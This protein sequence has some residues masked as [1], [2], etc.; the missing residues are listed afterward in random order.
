MHDFPCSLSFR[1]PRRGAHRARPGR[2]AGAVLLV[3]ASLALPVRAAD[4]TGGE[5]PGAFVQLGHSEDAAALTA[6]LVWSWPRH[7]SLAGGRLRLRGEVALSRWRVADP[8]PGQARWLSVVAFVPALRWQPRQGESP[9]FFEVGVGASYLSETYRRD[10]QSFSTRWNFADHLALGRS[11]G[12]GGR[13]ELSL[14]VQH[15]SNGG[16][17]KPNPGEDFVQLRYAFGFP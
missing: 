6:G 11:F 12:A 7:W 4:P 3:L 9:W 13:H 8:E 16:A 5:S 1:R 14:R 10:G 15:Y 17:R 2:L